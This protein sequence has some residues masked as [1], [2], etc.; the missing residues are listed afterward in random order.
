MRDVGLIRMCVD[1]FCFAL[2]C[3]TGAVAVV[4]VA[5]R[6][7]ILVG[8]RISYTVETI[9][10]VYPRCGHQPHTCESWSGPPSIWQPPLARY[11]ST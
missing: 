6:Q 2:L 9:G 3:C 7:M 4:L 8:T 5:I 10:H 1:L 11:T